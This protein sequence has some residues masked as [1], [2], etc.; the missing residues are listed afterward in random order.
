MQ[1]YYTSKPELLRQN[2]QLNYLAE[3]IFQR[4]K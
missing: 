2:A 1:N 4:N 3:P